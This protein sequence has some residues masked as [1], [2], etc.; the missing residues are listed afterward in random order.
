MTDLR[1]AAEAPSAPPPPPLIEAAVPPADPERAAAALAAW[2]AH[3]APPTVAPH[4]AALAAVLDRGD[5]AVTGAALAGFGAS[6]AADGLLG[7]ARARARMRDEPGFAQD[8]AH[9]THGAL[10]A[11]AE[12]TGA[13]GVEHPR[14]TGAARNHAIAPDRLFAAI[15]KTL[16]ADLSPPHAIG[17]HL[18]LAIGDGRVAHLRAIEAIHAAWRLR[19]VAALVGGDRIVEVG[20]GLGLTAWYARAL[21]L[22]G[23]AVADHPLLHA[24]RR[25][26]MGD[27]ARAVGALAET[28]VDLLFS[29]DHLSGLP[30]LHVRAIG[31][32]AAGAGARA[33]LVVDHEAPRARTP[34]AALL[35]ASGWRTA[36]RAHHGIRPGY[37]EQLFVRG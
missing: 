9:A 2:R 32:I 8:R 5:I 12:A 14:L 29:E 18:G 13:I 30:E 27:V 1:P 11:L 10:V 37:V 6:A 34:L 21:A 7:G 33:M 3:P 28:P 35:R 26:A 19:Q 4:R 24:V 16:G 15:E 23:H 31:G 17:G 22:A 36:W 25:Y 20:G